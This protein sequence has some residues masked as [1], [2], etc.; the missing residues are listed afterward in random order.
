[1][2]PFD[3]TEKAAEASMYSN[4]V[5][6]TEAACEAVRNSSKFIPNA[7]FNLVGISQGSL[8]ARNLVEHCSDL[9]VRN[10]FTIGGPHRGTH[11]WPHCFAQSEFCESITY[12][13]D[14]IQYLDILQQNSCGAA[15]W[16]DPKQLEVY[17]EKS[18]FLPYLNNEKDFSQ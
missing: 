6:Y 17:L 14:N 16:R 8:V 2:A 10:L 1:M 9:K 5:D 13:S 3:D 7:E 12:I 18:I 11:A 4:F 15:Y